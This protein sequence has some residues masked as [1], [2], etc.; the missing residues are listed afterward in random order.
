MF[1]ADERECMSLVSL[2]K[3]VCLYMLFQSSGCTIR[4]PSGQQ[5]QSYVTYHSVRLLSFI[6]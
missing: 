2:Y 4:W 3:Y 5:A 6:K 1:E